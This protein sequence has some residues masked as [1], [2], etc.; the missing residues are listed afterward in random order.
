MSQEIPANR[1]ELLSVKKRKKLAQTG[2][3]LLEKKRDALI[4]KFFEYVKEYRELAADTLIQLAQAYEKLHVAQAVSGVNRVKSL[5]YSAQESFSAKKTTNNIMG[6]KIDSLEIHKTAV[7]HNAS[8]IGT[9]NYV[10]QAR[11]S[12]QQ[13]V[14]ELVKL[15]E[16]E[17][18]IF[19]LA[20]EIRKTKRRVNALEHIY[21]PRL[22]STQKRISDRL[23]EIEREE[24][25][26]LKHVKEQLEK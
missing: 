9:S 18:T 12:F 14:P 15:A 2:H 16:L 1:M 11:E 24:F 26:R 19:S 17:Q 25:T 4:Q 13:V 5:A 21:L 7:T 10:T 20:D 23:A 3:N 8:L 6:V 22:E